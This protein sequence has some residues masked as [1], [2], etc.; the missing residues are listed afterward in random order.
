LRQGA[1]PSRE[2]A[3]GVREQVAD[4]REEATDLRE[5]AMTVRETAL[6]VREET[7]RAK[8]KLGATEAHLRE[9][10]EHLVVATMLAQTMTAN[11]EQTSAQL[12]H[13][14]EHDFLTGLP[15][16]AL[17]NDRLT[18]AIALAQ[19]HHDKKVALLFLDLDHFKHINDTL[20]HAVGD[21]LLQSAAKRLLACVRHS[22]TVS[23]QGGDEFVVLLS[24]VDEAQDA[25]RIAEKLIKA[26][27]EPHL[28]DGHRLHVTLSI[29]VSFY[30]D[31]GKDIDAVMRNADTAMY[32]AKRNGRNNY[33]TFSPDMAGHDAA[34]QSVAQVLQH[35]LDQHEFILYYQPKV[36]LDTGTI[37]GAEALL[38]LQ[39]SGR[40]IVGPEKFLGIASDS[41][42]ILP[43]GNWVRHEAC[44]QAKAWLDAGLELQQV[45]VNVS[46]DEFHSK[47]FLAGL[48]AALEETGLDPQLLEIELSEGGLMQDTELTM[49]TLHALKELGVRIAIDGFGTGYSSLND[50][51]RF[52]IDTLKIDRSFVNHIHGD[53]T[54]AIIVNAIIAMG[55]S[56][57]QRVVAEGI[58]T[59]EQLDFLQS[60]HCAEGQ[61]FYFGRPI[62]AEQ[63]AALLAPG[64]HERM[65]AATKGN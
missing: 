5:D 41:G 57:N 22:D 65:T 53:S 54:E 36:N 55:K 64:R 37:T 49:A 13:M 24:E 35:A 39:R 1:S 27:A 50:L 33:Q 56:L 40:D 9:A 48:H 3:A 45:S 19:R 28:I 43:I 15:N 46:V 6:R 10:N 59:R 47:E 31:D 26:M 29:G 61:G 23:R 38:R 11:A 32:Q 2:E 17:L 58:E 34:R 18:Q 20:G 8:A 60:R 16:R 4:R 52:P 51:R 12:S 25:T 44:R 62:A 7:A 14:A 42:L 63:F 21:Q 30:P